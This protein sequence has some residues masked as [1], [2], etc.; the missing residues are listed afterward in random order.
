VR[1]LLAKLHLAETLQWSPAAG[2]G[3]AATALHH[4]FVCKADNLKRHQFQAMKDG[5]R[6][7]SPQS[8][9]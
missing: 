7:R 3:S 6:L 2:A 8:L 1:V 4:I 9:N 5:S